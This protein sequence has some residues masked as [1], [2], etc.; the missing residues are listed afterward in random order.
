MKKIDY[1]IMVIDDDPLV[2][3]DISMMYEEMAR[4]G[5]FNT[6]F[7]DDTPHN[8]ARSDNIST[9][10]NAAEAEEVLSRN[11]AN[12]P[13]LFQLLHV[14]QR[15]PGETG[16]EFVD[17][18]RWR[19]TNHNI[20][21]ILVTGYSTD[22]SVINSREKGVYR[23]VSK[24]V[25]SELILPHLEDLVSMMLL[26]DKPV[27]RELEGVYLFRRL[28]TFEHLLENHK[29][30]YMRWG[31]KMLNYIPEE[32]L[33]NETG[34]EFDD[35]DKVS[36]ALGGFALRENED[37]AVLCRIITQ[38]KQEGYVHIANEIINRHGD[39]ILK[40]AFEKEIR[41]QNTLMRDCNGNGNFSN[42]I[43]RYGLENSVEFSRMMITDDEY[44]G[45]GL[46][47]KMAQ[48]H[49][50]VSKYELKA[51][52]GLATC[53]V[54][55]VKH[56]IQR[57]AF[58]GIIPDV[59]MIEAK[60]VEQVAQAIYVDLNKISD[61]PPDFHDRVIKDSFDMY[62]KHGFLCYCKRKDCIA[63]G[64]HI[65]GSSECERKKQGFD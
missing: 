17:R 41:F 51:K 15:M 2:L 58:T 37:L 9:A 36:V 4:F 62:R 63:N 38:K 3:E 60:R 26:K 48:F 31:P 64:Y 55:H 29:K 43:K 8:F 34:L 56:N 46:S 23:Y 13:K 39:Q 20:G 47:T 49:D 21:A 54:K 28:T 45:L 7:G 40:K 1:N 53:L 65:D 25:T 24:P 12:N 27:K 44:R 32:F 6:L 19:Y 10:K 59:G 42:F 35:F 52:I 50:M 11:I 5:D 30:R 14:D 57:N 22:V 33:S 16:S 18:M 61:E